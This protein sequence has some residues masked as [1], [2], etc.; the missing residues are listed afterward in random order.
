MMDIRNK[1]LYQNDGINI[2]RFKDG[3][4]VI[5]DMKN[6]YT[7]IL[8]ATCLQILELCNGKSSTDICHDISDK[9]LEEIS[10]RPELMQE[11]IEDV[12]DMLAQLYEKG[13]IYGKE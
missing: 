3:D 2:E 11:I 1:R 8:N 12:N 7:H 6:G 5:M 10:G 13:I 9:H 4:A